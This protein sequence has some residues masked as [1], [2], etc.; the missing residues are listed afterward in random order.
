MV[1]MIYMNS[2]IDL[3]GIREMLN[4]IGDLIDDDRLTKTVEN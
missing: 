2:W 1:H 4:M 3:Q